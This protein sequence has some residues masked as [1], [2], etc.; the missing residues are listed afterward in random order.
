MPHEFDPCEAPV[1]GEVDKWGF[2]IKP[3][4]SDVEC[5]LL[6]LKNAPCGT[7]RKQVIRLIEEYESK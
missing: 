5:I 6:C 3:L 1:E 2:T 7:D 4:I